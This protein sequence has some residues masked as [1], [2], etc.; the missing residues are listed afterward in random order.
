MSTLWLKVNAVD[1][2]SDRESYTFELSF[3]LDRG[4]LHRFVSRPM[5]DVAPYLRQIDHRMRY[6][7][8]PDSTDD[9][10]LNNIVRTVGT[11]LFEGLFPTAMQRLLRDRLNDVETVML[12]SNELEIPW[13]LVWVPNLTRSYP[14]Q[15]GLYLGQK[16][17]VRWPN[18]DL[19]GC[20]PPD[21]IRL[22][23][24]RVY[25]IVPTY[26]DPAEY[27]DAA[28]TERSYLVKHLQS[29]PV[30]P[31]PKSL[32]KLFAKPG[33]FDLMHFAGHGL[34]DQ[35]LGEV[36]ALVLEQADENNS[37]YEDH[38]MLP[39][40]LRG[41]RGNCPMIVLNACYTGRPGF[42]KR[43]VEFGAGAVLGASWPVG[44][45]AACTFV[46]TFYELLF[47]G[48]DLAQAVTQARQAAQAHPEWTWLSYVVYGNPHCRVD[49]K[50]LEFDSKPG[51]DVVK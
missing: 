33:S 47:Q 2:A 9:E 36:L 4:E 10:T 26:E 38:Q 29:R 1:R 45:E 17:L 50:L 27:L 40:D 43:L 24:G 21:K 3:D 7:F 44:D 39:Y 41:P 48:N 32:D 16:G 30:D 6:V 13:E 46:L 14:P 11:H 23:P 15:Q 20:E 34:I 28:Q 19:V 49:A 37:L 12:L 31:E 35:S 8:G 18:F 51:L 5:K 25:H 22:R 42:S